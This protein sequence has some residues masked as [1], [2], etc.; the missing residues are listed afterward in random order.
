MS[1]FLPSTLIDFEYFDLNNDRDYEK[2]AKPYSKELDFA[3]FVVNF[4]YSKQDYEALTLKEKSFI[5][6]AW[7]NKYASNTMQMYNANF[8]ALYNINRGKNKRAL[9][10]LKKK[11]QK[12]VDIEMIRNNVKIIKEVEEKEGFNWINKIYAANNLIP[13]E[14]R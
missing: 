4:G 1:F 3:F 8:T 10:V 5:Y 6:K 2:I 9:K 11:K 12:K 13:P 14:R 7:E